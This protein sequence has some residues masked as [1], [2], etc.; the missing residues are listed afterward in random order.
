MTARRARTRLAASLARR[1]LP[2]RTRMA[3]RE[4]TDRQYVDRERVRTAR[5][6]RGWSMDQAGARAGF[7][8]LRP[9]HQWNK[10]ENGT[11]ANPQIGTL[12]RIAAALEL[13][14]TD[15]LLD[16]PT[17]PRKRRA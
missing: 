9:G 10:I 12:Y 17:A 5:E 3:A 8:G 13:D 11:S 16:P 14:L 6:A 1:S 7:Q 15:I 4:N 2:D